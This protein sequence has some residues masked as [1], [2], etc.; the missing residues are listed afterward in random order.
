MP[1]EVKKEIELGIAH[2]LFIDIVAYSKLSIN[3]QFRKTEAAKPDLKDPYP[4]WHGAGLLQGPGG[5]GMLKGQR[6]RFAP[7]I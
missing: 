6:K 1:A 4:R 5:T 2:L 3:E 7:K